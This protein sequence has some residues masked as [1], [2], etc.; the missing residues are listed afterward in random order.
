MTTVVICLREK[1]VL[2]TLKT[3]FILFAHCQQI[4]V[5]AIRIYSQIYLYKSND[6]FLG[7]SHSK[8]VQE[9][10]LNIKRS[11]EFSENVR[12]FRKTFIS[13]FSMSIF[14]ANF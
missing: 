7:L 5:I 6:L 9:S 14:Q 8:V 10:E 3:I 2:Q 12:D 13:A 4:N 1:P 11:F